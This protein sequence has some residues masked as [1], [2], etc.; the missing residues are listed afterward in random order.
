MNFSTPWHKFVFRLIF[1]S[2]FW[3]RVEIQPSNF[4][5][6]WDK[7]VFHLRTFPTLWDNICNSTLKNL[8]KWVKN[9]THF[10]SFATLWEKIEI[11]N[12]KKFVTEIQICYSSQ[13][14]FD[15]VRH[16]SNSTFK[17][18]GNVRQNVNHFLNFSTL[19]H[20]FVIG[21]ILFSTFRDKIEILL[22]NFSAL[23]DKSVNHLIFFSTLWHKIVIQLSKFLEL[24]VKIVTHFINFSTLWEKIEIH[25]Q[26]FRHCDTK[27]LF[28][29]KLLRRCGTK[30]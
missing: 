17:T 29:S 18:F 28:T 8:S 24:W 4:S 2:A 16:S 6:L 26:S 23:W 20:K 7:F 10:I 19:W 25:S 21:L 3:D 5:A 11:F 9:V 1:C 15:V 14:F 13:N 22:S 12:S 30:L 27:L